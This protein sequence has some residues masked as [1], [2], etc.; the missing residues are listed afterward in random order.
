VE[1]LA[2][3]GGF[4]SVAGLIELLIAAAVLSAGAGGTPH[5]LL[6]LGWLILASLLASRYFVQR[7]SWTDARLAISHDVIEK[8]VGH[9][10]RLAQQR[11]ADWHEGEDSSL[12]QYL[13]LS[14]GWTDGGPEFRPVRAGW[15][16]ACSVSS[17]RSS[18]G[19]AA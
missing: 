1:S 3:S 17:P 12:A 16:S 19:R 15:P 5:V 9:R 8:M 11:P 13:E 18:P 2:L 10:T 6:L 7:R 4:L 14:R